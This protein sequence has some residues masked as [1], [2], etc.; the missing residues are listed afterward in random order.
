MQLFPEKLNKPWCPCSIFANSVSLGLIQRSLGHVLSRIA[1]D[2]KAFE[3]RDPP[4]CSWLSSEAQGRFVLKQ[5]FVSTVS[6][7][8]TT[9]QA[10]LEIPGE[11]IQGYCI[12]HKLYVPLT[13]LMYEIFNL[14]NYLGNMNALNYESI[15]FCIS[16]KY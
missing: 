10:S 5:A 13:S 8:Q 7:L 11:E 3:A 15:F 9:L 2:Q 14:K 1:Q 12:S 4:A 16:Q 6:D